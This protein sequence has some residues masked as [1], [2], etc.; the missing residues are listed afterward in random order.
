MNMF[1]WTG[2][3]GN[4]APP[5]DAGTV[6]EDASELPGANQPYPM[7]QLGKEKPP[8]GAKAE[9]GKTE[10]DTKEKA[11][12]SETKEGEAKPTENKTD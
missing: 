9:A 7:E 10:S 1:V 6:I 5:A 11:T 12:E 3:G 8:E 2:C 4:P